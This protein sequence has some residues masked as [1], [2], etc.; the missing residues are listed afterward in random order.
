MSFGWYGDFVKAGAIFAHL[1][2]ASRRLNWQGA[3]D[4]TYRAGCT[5]GGFWLV[6]KSSRP[7]RTTQLTTSYLSVRQSGPSRSIAVKERIC[8]TGRAIGGLLSGR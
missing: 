2:F 6:G 1:P 3:D 7:K 5:N 4:V 8:L